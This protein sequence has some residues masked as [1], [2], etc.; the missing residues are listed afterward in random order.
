VADILYHADDGRASFNVAGPRRVL[1]SF[2][3]VQTT[4]A[5][6]RAS[7]IHRFIHVNNASINAITAPATTISRMSRTDLSIDRRYR[8]ILICTRSVPQEQ[9]IVDSPFSVLHVGHVM[10]VE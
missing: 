3:T 2:L 9:R 5:F 7:I 8:A 1:T 10:T 6:W 4:L